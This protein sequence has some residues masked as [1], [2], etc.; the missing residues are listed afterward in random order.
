MKSKYML[1]FLVFQGNE[2]VQETQ[3]EQDFLYDVQFNEALVRFMA[4]NSRAHM[5]PRVRE[6]WTRGHRP[7]EI[8]LP[9]VQ[10]G[11]GPTTVFVINRI[12]REIIN[13][14]DEKG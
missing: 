1:W 6:I 14:P 4:M 7:N 9:H 5:E 10:S 13:D 8:I 11:L 3:T 2:L 12:E